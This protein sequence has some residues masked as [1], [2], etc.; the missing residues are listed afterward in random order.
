MANFVGDTKAILL[1]S[2]IKSEI[3]VFEQCH[4]IGYRP[5]KDLVL[6][7][8]LV[9]NINTLVMAQNNSVEAF[10]VT[11]CT[12]TDQLRQGDEL[13]II[14]EVKNMGESPA[15]FCKYHTPFEGTA[16]EIFEVLKDGK[17]IPYQGKLKKRR[18]PTDKDYVDLGPR[19]SI[20][21]EVRLNEEYDIVEKGHYTIRFLGSVI[22]RLN[23]SNEITFE[24][25]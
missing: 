11:I 15:R 5:M 10:E 1:E 16:N 18:P 19:Q 23:D 22:S 14:T 20:T 4:E 6:L 8:I 2:F 17:K 13:F 24:I 21:C 12:T 25:R 9:L 7:V 3:P